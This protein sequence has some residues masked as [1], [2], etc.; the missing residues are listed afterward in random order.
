MR[1]T[2]VWWAVLLASTLFLFIAMQSQSR[3]H[4]EHM[5]LNFK[6]DDTYADEV[7]E[8]DILPEEF[9]VSLSR[10]DANTPQSLL[11]LWRAKDFFMYEFAA[12]KDW[13]A[14]NTNSKLAEDIEPINL[15]ESL[16]IGICA[17]MMAESS[18]M[19]DHVQGGVPFSRLPA[20]G[21]ENNT[22]F[23]IIQW[24]GGRRLSL[25]SWCQANSLDAR[26]L[27]T[28]LHYLAY[29]YYS[30]LE[31]SRWDEVLQTSGEDSLFGAEMYAEVFRSQ[32]ERGGSAWRCDEIL[33]DW[34]NKW[35]AA[36]GTKPEGG[37][38]GYLKGAC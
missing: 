31:R 21:T 15:P 17:N 1:S 18:A 20:L 12:E 4:Y 25:L 24:D 14:K 6:V 33:T 37:L 26:N 35:S 32:I 22:G 2:K 28:Q 9:Q 27:T 7:P 16:A 34:G 10:W 38:Y 23:G 5:V 11:N 29:E 19:P 13:L 8:V 30:G 3:P 36:W